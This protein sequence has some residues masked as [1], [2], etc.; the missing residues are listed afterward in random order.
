MHAA[1]QEKSDQLETGSTVRTFLVFMDLPVHYEYRVHD[2]PILPEGMEIEFDTV[3]TN[4]SD[5]TLK[6]RVTG[7]Y[8]VSRRKIR[9]STNQPSKL[10]LTQYLELS[11]VDPETSEED[12]EVSKTAEGGAQ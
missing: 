1:H 5:P 9:Y 4:P 2:M 11:P 3:L 6:R 10:G 12:E 7:P 8:C